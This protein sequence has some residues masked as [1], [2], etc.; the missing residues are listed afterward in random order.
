MSEA[1]FIETY[2]SAFLY[3]VRSNKPGTSFIQ[4]KEKNRNPTVFRAFAELEEFSF[5]T[6]NEAERTKAIEIVKKYLDN[7]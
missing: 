1:K 6:D 3:E 7:R 5:P 4:Y 2:S